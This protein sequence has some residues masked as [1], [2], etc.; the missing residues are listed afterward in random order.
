M[1]EGK[2]NMNEVNELEIISK[3]LLNFLI[4]NT[5][6]KKFENMLP[7]EIYNKWS[8][9]YGKGIIFPDNVNW[10]MEFIK[11]FKVSK[12]Q[13]NIIKHFLGRK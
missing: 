13:Q 4:H 1:L 9:T 7:Y 11:N 3:N 8:S 5:E 10:A 12:E 2:T 6:D